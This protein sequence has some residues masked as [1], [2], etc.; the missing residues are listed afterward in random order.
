MLLALVVFPQEAAVE[1]DLS[2]LLKNSNSKTKSTRL[3]AILEIGKQ[4]ASLKT[5][6]QLK[7]ADVL[8]DGIVDRDA[9]LSAAAKFR[10][11]QNPAVVNQ[12]LAPYM[13]SDDYNQFAKGCE[14]IKVIGP[15]AKIW[16]GDM[17]KYLDSDDRNFRLAALHSI[18]ALDGKDILPLLDYITPSLS[19]QDFNIQLSACRAISK[20]GPSARKAAP[21]L[22]ELLEKGN[23]SV[24]S[25]ASIALG[26]IGPTAEHDV[27]D[28][29]QQRLDRFYVIDRERALKGLAYLGAEAKSTLPKVKK[30]MENPDKSVQHIAARTYWKISGDPKPAVEILTKLIPTMIYGADSMSILAEMGADAKSAVP[31][32]VKHLQSPEVT[33]RESACYAL[34]AIGPDAASAI[35]PL[36][37]MATDKDLLVRAI[38]EMAIEEIQKKERTS[39]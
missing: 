35:E 17:E 22:V 21:K 9:V 20:I 13:K 30:L 34:A 8:I 6:D 16:I 10:S 14:A 27:V 29:L 28:L 24:R 32:I 19:N 39:K 12:Y 36:K 4:I 5:S 2:E 31:E 11:G 33:V 38:A 18:A 26:S 37:Q 23:A 1:T 25:W 3:K 15:E 7:A